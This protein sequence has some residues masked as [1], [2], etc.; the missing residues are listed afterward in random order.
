L[1]IEGQVEDVDL[2]V[3]GTF[4]GGQPPDFFF[5]GEA[6]KDDVSA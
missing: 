4:E 6:V 5:R 1:D 3:D 2:V